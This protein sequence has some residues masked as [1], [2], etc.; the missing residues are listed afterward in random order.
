MGRGGARRG[1]G[2]RETAGAGLRRQPREKQGGVR[3]RAGLSETTGERLGAG[4]FNQPQGSGGLGRCRVESRESS[5]G[6]PGA[7]LSCRVEL[8]ESRAFLEEEQGE[9]VAKHCGSRWGGASGKSWRRRSQ[10]APRLSVSRI[11]FITKFWVPASGVPDETKRLLVLHPHCYFQNSGLVV[12]SLHCSMSVLT[13]LEASVFLPSVRCAYFSLEKLEEAGML[14]MRDLVHTGAC[15]SVS[16]QGCFGLSI[17]LSTPN[18]PAHP[19]CMAL[20]RPCILV[21]G[22]AVGSP[23][24]PASLGLAGF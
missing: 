7:Q 24:P 11:D 15:S 4:P 18:Y 2:L 1:A 6:G 8:R 5:V 23:I 20:R 22:L 10:A 9:A 19:A 16:L 14:E 12:W 17:H 3:G 13:N 21:T